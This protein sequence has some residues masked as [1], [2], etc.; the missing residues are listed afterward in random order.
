MPVFGPLFE[1]VFAGK[2]R[3]FPQTL[4]SRVVRYDKVRYLILST[5][6]LR[7]RACALHR[8][9]PAMAIRWSHCMIPSL[10]MLFTSIHSV[11]VMLPRPTGA[12]LRKH[13]RLAGHSDLQ[14]AATHRGSQQGGNKWATMKQLIFFFTSV[15]VGTAHSA[16][17]RL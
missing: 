17:C 15:H 4:S 3:V 1:F 5:K 14:N 2:H 13:P 7:R 12:Y 6:V 16:Y 10:K 8:D 11:L 9:S